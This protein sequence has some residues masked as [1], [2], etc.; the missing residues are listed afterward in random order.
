MNETDA[1]VTP[2]EVTLTESQSESNCSHD[3]TVTSSN[4]SVTS[5]K[6]PRKRKNAKPLPNRP[7]WT[8][9]L[10]NTYSKAEIQEHKA[11]AKRIL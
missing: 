6:K 5:S 8:D 10:W 3:T 9:D 7:H 1:T 2:G 4:A 11:K